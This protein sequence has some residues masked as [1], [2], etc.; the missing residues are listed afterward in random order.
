MSSSRERRK[1]SVPWCPP[2]RA[3]PS[4]TGAFPG[5]PAGEAGWPSGSVSFCMGAFAMRRGVCGGAPSPSSAAPRRPL[6]RAL[7]AVVASSSAR[8]EPTSRG[9]LLLLLPPLLLPPLL[10]RLPS[11]LSPLSQLPRRSRR[12]SAPCSSLTAVAAAA[13]AIS[14]PWRCMR[15]CRWR[16]MASKPRAVTSAGGSTSGQPVTLSAES[17]G[18][19]AS[20]VGS[21]VIGLWPTKSHLSAGSAPDATTC[22][23]SVS[24]LWER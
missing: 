4:P 1:L 13:A 18:S 24:W 14:S 2:V 17:D 9:L 21:S 11:P 6:P 5:A 12:G 20:A 15:C 8:S 22:G 19:S 3:P 16:R 7:A 10:L 23:I